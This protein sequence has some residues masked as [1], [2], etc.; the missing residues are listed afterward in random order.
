LLAKTENAA[1]DLTSQEKESP[2]S[3]TDFLLQFPAICV[4]EQSPPTPMGLAV[5][6]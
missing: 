5:Q 3:A 1:F 2:S 6:R 4:S